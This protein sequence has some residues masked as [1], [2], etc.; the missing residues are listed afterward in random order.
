MSKLSSV[1]Y[2]EFNLICLTSLNYCLLCANKNLIRRQ[3]RRSIMSNEE[4]EVIQPKGEAIIN[5]CPLCGV[6]F[7]ET[8]I[9]NRWLRCDSCDQIFQVKT[10]DKE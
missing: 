6:E 8:V 5:H 10:R 1:F 7:T 4:P 9:T 2:D 3:L